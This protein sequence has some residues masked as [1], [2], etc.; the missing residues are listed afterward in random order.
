MVTASRVYVHPTSQRGL[1]FDILLGFCLWFPEDL[2]EGR[3]VSLFRPSRLV[4]LILFL[5][6]H[7]IHWSA[8]QLFSG[9]LHISLIPATSCY[10]FA[11]DEMFF[12]VYQLPA[13][14]FLPLVT[15]EREVIVVIVL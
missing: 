11:P 8:F 2:R 6:L 13:T 5:H 14:L 15:L 9:E 4:L 1:E 7:F 10:N 12:R 3:I